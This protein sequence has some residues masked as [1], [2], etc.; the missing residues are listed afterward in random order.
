MPYSGNAPADT[1]ILPKESLISFLIPYGLEVVLFDIR[2]EVIRAFDKQG[3][4]HTD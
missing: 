1:S 4:V 3:T 2:L